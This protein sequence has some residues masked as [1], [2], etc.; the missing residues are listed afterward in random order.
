MTAKDFCSQFFF[1]QLRLNQRL[2]E[3][4]HLQS[5]AKKVTS[6]ISESP[7]GNSKDVSRIENSVAEIY[8]CTGKLAEE[9]S[10]T[11]TIREKILSA[12]KQLKNPNE[13]LVLELRYIGFDSWESIA[14]KTSFSLAHV[15]NLHRRALKKLESESNIIVNNS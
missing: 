2:K 13:R 1:L 6:T 14:K 10:R 3:I 11:V 9:I 15:F 5:M 12:I 8:E 7:S 4:D